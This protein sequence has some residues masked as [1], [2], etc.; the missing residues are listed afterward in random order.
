MW[1][2]KA[3]P[4]RQAIREDVAEAESQSGLPLG[5][6]ERPPGTILII[7]LV[8]FVVA[9]AVQ[10]WPADP[11]PFREGER[12]PYDLRAPVTFSVVD[13]VETERLREAAKATSPPV[14][15]LDQGVVD[16]L[17]SQL[18]ALKQDAAAGALPPE[19]AAR[20]PGLTE[21]GVRVL[22]SADGESYEAAV[23]TF[24]NRG[25]STM[26]L[27]TE[28]DR[29]ILEEKRAAEVRL[30]AGAG[31]NAPGWGAGIQQVFTVGAGAD[32][33]GVQEAARERVRAAAVEAFP[34]ALV[35]PMTNYVMGLREPTFRFDAKQTAA[36]AERQ[37]AQI[38]PQQPPIQENA[39][40]VKRGELITPEKYRILTE[41]RAAFEQAVARAHPWAVYWSR[42]GRVLMVLMVTAGG[43][44][45]V[46]RLTKVAKTTRQAWA[47][48]GLLLAMLV[49][50]KVVVAVAPQ[51]LY[52]MG[53]SPTLLVTIILV[54]AYNQRFALG[55]AALHG[56]LVT[57]TLGQGIDFYLPLMAGV[58]AFSF[59]L[60]EIRTRARLIE[61]GAVASAA[62]FGAVWA[63]GLARLVGGGSWAGGVVVGGSA[64]ALGGGVAA[65]VSWVAG[66]SLWA[67][68]SGVF[69]AMFALAALPSIERTFN[70]TTAMTLLELCDANRPLLR[71]LSQE[72][73]GT[74]N[75]SL[76]VG[77]M[78][79]AAGNAIGA[80]G[81]LCR[82][83][84]YYHDVGKLSKPQYF[85]E[86]Q[87]A[88]G[89][90]R[91]D[92]LSPAMSLLIIVG[93]V[94]D[95]IELAREYGLPWVVHQF[96]AQHHG[97]TLVE[98]FY[99]AARKR[100][101]A[102]GSDVEVSETE[103]RYP[104]PKPQTPEAAIVM[105]CDGCESAVRAIEEPTAGRIESTVH[106][107]I[108][109]RLMD[110]QFSECD[111]TLR[112]LSVIEE[113]LVRTLAAIHHG[114]VAY[115]VPAT[116]VGN[117]VAKTA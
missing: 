109:K 18:S 26:P 91:H 49:T 2:Q 48:C 10:F 11:L 62:I 21:A 95:G 50:A 33:G 77:I 12:A 117:G 111:L 115:P 23:R 79:E 9:A 101:E 43:A 72:A 75:H 59:G 51:M 52:W 67:V 74:F 16:R 24:L 54:I 116:P 114:R 83:G 65:D 56:L 44:L 27:V 87:S 14:L 85:I 94:K 99:H 38:M 73:A 86:N 84:A 46:S 80:N 81:L 71:R 66:Q 100:A 41:A 40:I 55:V 78:A 53:I 34:R 63:V 7:A 103:F 70:I 102:G 17:R 107:M 97:T 93:H 96:I 92:K 110:G 5:G 25:L 64:W 61:V 47:V 45:Y 69:V 1:F 113:T 15:V 3:S 108:M 68:A 36:F 22:A 30:M 13:P 106:N 58:A 28:A 32:G 42:L 104:G 88:G 37:A 60:S 105:I 82:V 112:D 90:N 57:V 98:Y 19:E 6:G 31:E 89:P 4:R 76:T 8:F 39:V 20:F 29:Q 35:E